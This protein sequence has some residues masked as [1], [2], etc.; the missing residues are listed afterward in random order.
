MTHREF[1]DAL[2]ALSPLRVI[3]LA[4]PSLFE[5]IC[6]LERYA[7][8]DGVLNAFSDQYHWHLDLSR[9]RHL[10]S[11]DE[12][13]ERSGR[14]VLYFT[15]REWADA[16]PFLLMYL[17]RGPREDFDAARE[18]HFAALHARLAAGTEI[19]P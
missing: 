15:L 11:H 9:F 19:V 7:I 17:F 3:S 12:I 14:R 18:T 6:R 16:E 1:F 13:H 2:R 5:A 8:R 10:R 4:G